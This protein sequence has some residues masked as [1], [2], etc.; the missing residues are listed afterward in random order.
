[1][2]KQLI[3]KTQANEVLEVLQNNGLDPAEFDWGETKAEG[4]MMGVGK[5]WLSVLTHRPTGWSFTFDLRGNP[6][7]RHGLSHWATYFPAPEKPRAF[8]PCDSWAAMRDHVHIWALTVKREIDAPDL[9]AAIAQER[10]LAG[11]AASLENTPFAEDESARLDTAVAE[12]REY[13]RSSVQMQQEQSERVDRQFEYLRGAIHR[14]A[15]Q[16]W[17]HT[18]IGVLF[19]VALTIGAEEARD[20]FRFAWQQIS[21]AIGLAISAANQFFLPG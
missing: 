16:D 18:A 13:L 10:A 5:A 6:H 14:M 12:I 11:S 2:E 1:M 17:L 15:R 7:D 21:T 20:L 4:G 3:H 8:E 19:T 9:W